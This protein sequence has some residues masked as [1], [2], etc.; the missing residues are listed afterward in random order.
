MAPN[1]KKKLSA[2]PARGFATTS[3]ASKPKSNDT[4]HSSEAENSITPLTSTESKTGLVKDD[5]VVE[6]QKEPNEL[7]PEEFEK[8]LEESELQSLVEQHA[9]KSKRDSARQVTRLQTERRVLRGQTERLNLRQWLPAEAI[10][11]ITE[12]I[13]QGDGNGSSR[14]DPDYTT[15]VATAS[16]EESSVRLWTLQQTL[17]ALDVPEVSIQEVLRSL[18]DRL[19]TFTS[20]SKGAGKD[21]IWGLEE[22]LDW[23]ALNCH[24]RDL[25]S[26]E[27][28]RSGPRPKKLDGNESLS[29]RPEAGETEIFAR[30]SSHYGG[31]LSMAFIE[32]SIAYNF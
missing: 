12:L 18:I 13:R 14:L 23:L 2:N 20:S 1:K 5:G 22:S 27:D 9:L 4:A 15:K 21:T 10:E 29:I 6:R 3:I 32:S 31:H 28:Q 26:Y 16:E 11:H 30:Y 17:Q 25:P 8:Q 24:Q 19:G 7:S